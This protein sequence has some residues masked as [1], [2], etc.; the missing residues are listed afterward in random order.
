M[1]LRGRPG[2]LDEFQ[3]SL[4]YIVEYYLNFKIKQAEQIL[5][6]NLVIFKI[7]SWGFGEGGVSLPLF[8][9]K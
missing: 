1:S 3:A 6:T 7:N 2:V 4:G 8:A 5:D 9:P